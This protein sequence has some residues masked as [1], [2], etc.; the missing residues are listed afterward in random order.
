MDYKS[1]KIIFYDDKSATM[2]GVVQELLN[3]SETVRGCSKYNNSGAI[4]IDI[5][6]EVCLQNTNQYIICRAAKSQR[7]LKI[8]PH[9][10]FLLF[11]CDQ[12]T[13]NMI[14]NH[15]HVAVTQFSGDTLSAIST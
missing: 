5:G 4:S 11:F 15:L 3:T 13:A 2:H 9:G 12:I 6:S 1:S 10:I 7:R 14:I 8:Q